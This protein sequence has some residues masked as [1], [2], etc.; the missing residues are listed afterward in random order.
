M[1]QITRCPSCTTTF[2][3]VPDQLRISEGWVRCGQCKTV[4]DA[5]AHLITLASSAAV[6]ASTQQVVSNAPSAD[7][8]PLS[9]Q[10][11]PLVHDSVPSRAV[12]SAVSA[13][14]ILEPG[15]PQKVLVQSNDINSEVVIPS[16]LMSPEVVNQ[17]P[18]VRSAPAAASMPSAQAPATSSRHKPIGP[19]SWTKPA[20]APDANLSISTTKASLEGQALESVSE[21]ASRSVPETASDSGS[22]T[23]IEQG[24][25][26]GVVSSTS[27]A[28]PLSNRKATPFFG[29]PAKK[30]SHDQQP[31]L[32]SPPASDV[33]FPTLH[34]GEEEGSK[35]ALNTSTAHSPLVESSVDITPAPNPDS[36]FA[37]DSDRLQASSIRKNRR[38][39]APNPSA[40]EMVQADSAITVSGGTAQAPEKHTDISALQEAL[41]PLVFPE[42]MPEI[43]IH[44]GMSL[45]YLARGE[46]A[47][48]EPMG[49]HD[50][51]S[52][53]EVSFVIAARRREFWRKPWVTGA[54]LFAFL[55]LVL[56]LCLQVGIRYRN[57]LAAQAP[58]AR[59]LLLQICPFL[60]CELAPV[61]H[62]DDL[63]IDSSAFNKA[64]GEGYLLGLTIK[65][66]SAIS[67]AMPAVELT[68]TD[69]QDQP[70]VRRVLYA[71]DMGAP[72][73][74]AASGEW[75]ATLPVA[76]S[77]PSTRIAGYR[78]AIFYP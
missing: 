19:F 1:S 46:Q 57:E 26:F 14:A 48:R 39:P 30:T 64:R 76:V 33:P 55:M 56:L 78:L 7:S 29:I 40:A 35:S 50:A 44:S 20:L 38:H 15:E 69:N 71:H 36:G 12:S 18:D 72:I 16:F 24:K 13:A 42:N 10:S 4:F 51:Q 21:P 52:S 65:N 77:A 74:I 61:R 37:L 70:V 28:S 45:P 31:I 22:N 66:R 62:I 68:L 53:E 23:G 75:N 9:A 17:K 58:Q 5:S 47:L 3:V 11:A 43:K 41:P 54:L 49:G 63:V 2:K 25:D 34:A 27:V 6:S 73:E 60:H 8:K 67:V 59:A 32:T